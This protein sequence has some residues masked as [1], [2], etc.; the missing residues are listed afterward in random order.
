MQFRGISRETHVG[1][2]FAGLKRG[3][4]RAEMNTR[5][6]SQRDGISRSGL[7]AILVH[8]FFQEKPNTTTRPRLA[9]RR[10]NTHERCVYGKLISLF[11][12]VQRD[13]THY[14]QPDTGRRDGSPS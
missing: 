13:M 6:G 14:N 12:S 2:N 8:A 7:R 10:R 3:I 4:T 9:H 5:G 11:Y 1:S